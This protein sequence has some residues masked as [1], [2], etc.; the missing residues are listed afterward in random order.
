[1]AEIRFELPH[2]ST[3]DYVDL[4]TFLETQGIEVAPDRA[5]AEGS[6]LV[7]VVAVAIIGAGAT[8]AASAITAFGNYLVNRQAKRK[9]ETTTPPPPVV[10]LIRGLSGSETVQVSSGA[11]IVAA[12]ID[13]AV[14]NVGPVTGVSAKEG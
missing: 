4:K 9:S 10:I 12:A 14:A 3:N 8:V 5:P 6:A 7:T 11:G 1:M 13:A 2:A